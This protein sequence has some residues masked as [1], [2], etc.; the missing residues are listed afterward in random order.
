MVGQKAVH[1]LV[2]NY[3]PYEDAMCDD[4]NVGFHAFLPLKPQSFDP[5][6]LYDE[7]CIYSTCLFNFKSILY[8]LVNAFYLL[9]LSVS[10]V[11]F[12]WIVSMTGI[13]S[14]SNMW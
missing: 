7:V 8:L 10:V 13:V 1:S 3:D 9:Q 5:N 14:V 11:F 6:I 12:I 4:P 2:D